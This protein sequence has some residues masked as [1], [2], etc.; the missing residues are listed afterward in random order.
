MRC[1]SSSRRSTIPCVFCILAIHSA[2]M[3]TNIF[4]LSNRICVWPW[5]VKDKA[6]NSSDSFFESGNGPVFASSTITTCYSNM[7]TPYLKP[8]RVEKCGRQPMGLS[9]H[10]FGQISSHHQ[11]ISPC[12][13]FT[14]N[15][16]HPHTPH[17]R[18]FSRDIILLLLLQQ[19]ISE[20]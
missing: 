12:T 11:H 5:L 19:L 10:N 7:S 9:C 16:Q 13:R 14:P 2:N 8:C 15:S 18:S 17:P 4:I 6:L 1:L 3:S 20:P